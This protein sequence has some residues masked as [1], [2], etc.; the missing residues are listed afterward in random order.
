METAQE[1]DR[2]QLLKRA[3]VDARYTKEYSISLEDLE[4]LSECIKVLEKL[5]TENFE[6]VLQA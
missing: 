4:Y 3:Y 2:F 1:K 5:T 6:K